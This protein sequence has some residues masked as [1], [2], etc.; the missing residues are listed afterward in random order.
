MLEKEENY[1]EII[2]TYFAI[3]S[4]AFLYSLQKKI[5]NLFYQ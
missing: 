3:E 1:D 4:H 2:E 5:E